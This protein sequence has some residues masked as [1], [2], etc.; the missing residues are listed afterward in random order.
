MCDRIAVERRA[1]RYGDAFNNA[2]HEVLDRF[3]PELLVAIASPSP[4]RPDC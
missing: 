1:Q 4:T 3:D 2:I